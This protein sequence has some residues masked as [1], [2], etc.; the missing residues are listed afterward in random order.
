ME[1]KM[2]SNKIS[3]DNIR[4]SLAAA[5]DPWEAGVTSVSALPVEQQIARLGVSPPPGTPTPDFRAKSASSPAASSVGAP[6]S[7]F[8]GQP[9]ANNYVTPIKD[10]GGCGSCVSF[11][12]TAVVESMIRIQRGN[13]N[14]DID[15]S[16]AHLFFCHGPATG[17]SCSNGWWPVNAFDAYK[18]Q[19]VAD[20]ACFPYNAG[21]TGCSACGDAAS[22]SVKIT[23]HKDLTNNPA[24]IKEWVSTKGPVSACFAVFQDFFNYRSGVYR[25]VSGNQVGGHCVTI[26]GYDDAAGYWLCK[27]SW[28]TGWGDQGWF[29]IA[30]GECGIDTWNVMGVESVENTGWRSNVRVAGLW[31]INQD[32]NAWAYMDG[33]GWRKISA[34][35]DNILFD[36]LAQLIAAK[37]KGGVV[38]FYEEQS[39]I[40]QIY[41][42]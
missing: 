35:N 21:A 37:A 9:G 15:L 4:Q 29:A 25:H 34:E 30:Y 14:L 39:V 16:E 24:A 13:P 7:F 1:D 17:A 38:S 27:N 19:G 36:M 6:S 22:R 28:G 11:G 40:K 42:F 32:R 10:Q 8:W 31:T 23:G 33:F 5:G 41:A 3:L 26:V 2:S 20:E 18:A 12:T